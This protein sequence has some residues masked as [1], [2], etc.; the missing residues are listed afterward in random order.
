MVGNHYT[1]ED[2][3][4][5]PIR[6]RSSRCKC[7]LIK[8]Q[9]LVLEFCCFFLSVSATSPAQLI[10]TKKGTR[11]TNRTSRIPFAITEKGG[12]GLLKLLLEKMD[13]LAPIY[14]SSISADPFGSC[15][16]SFKAIPSPG[17]VYKQA[18]RENIG[19]S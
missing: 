4:E 17:I 1:C 5:M 9:L 14:F 10:P 16:F 18:G 8:K 15:I 3:T 6:T 19:N 12:D 13:S 2:N 7:C 11:S